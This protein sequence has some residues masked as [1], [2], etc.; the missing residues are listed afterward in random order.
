MTIRKLTASDIEAAAALTPGWTAADYAAIA[1]GDFPDRLCLITGERN[2][3][4]L[5]S[6]VPPDAEILN[7]FVHPE[8]RRQGQTRQGIHRL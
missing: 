2:G 7:I 6:M 4:V 3:L 5:A 8:A 1:R